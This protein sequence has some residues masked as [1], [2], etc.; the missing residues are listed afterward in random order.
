MLRVQFPAWEA[1]FSE[2]ADGDL[3]VS[4]RTALEPL[5]VVQARTLETLGA[6]SVVVARQVHGT[7]VL[8]VHEAPVGYEVGRGEGDGVASGLRGV[9]TAVHVGDCLPIAVGGEGA[10]ATLHGGWRGLAEGIVAA[11]V[12]GLRELG[13]GGELQAVIGPG[14]GGCCYETGDELRE[15]FA[16]Y[17]ASRGTLLDLKAVAAAQLREAGVAVVQDVGVCTICD[18]RY[19]SHR[20]DGAATGRQG[21]F[22]WLR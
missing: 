16:R 10:V 18:A 19:F 4:A 2:A 12:D 1:A 22:A 3:R 8:F 21:G 9:A 15:R 20:R 7:D 11:G 17:G 14:A 6:A 5:G 13:V